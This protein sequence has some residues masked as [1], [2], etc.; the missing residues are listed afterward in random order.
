M[1]AHLGVRLSVSA[2]GPAH[3]V[4]ISLLRVARGCC[5]DGL[6]RCDIRVHMNFNVLVSAG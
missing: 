2:S 6:V 1:R 5:G 4:H 3:T